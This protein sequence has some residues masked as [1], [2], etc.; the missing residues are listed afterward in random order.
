M[1]NQEW[2]PSLAKLYPL[3]FAQLVFRFFR[4]DAVDGEPALGVVDK[5]EV[6]SGFLDTDH[7]HEAGWE[8]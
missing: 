5:S 1:R 3:D 4:G 2:D 7:V 6:L 8:R